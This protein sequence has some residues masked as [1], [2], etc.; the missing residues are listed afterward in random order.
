MGRMKDRM[1]NGQLYNGG[2]M[3][4]GVVIR[5][6]FRCERDRVRIPEL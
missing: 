6:P 5:P 3:G 2:R 4:D 1:L